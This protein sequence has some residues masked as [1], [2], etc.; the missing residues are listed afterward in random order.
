MEKNARCVCEIAP[1][2]CQTMKLKYSEA[3]M[4]GV[5]VCAEAFFT[6]FK[7]RSYFP[8]DSS[9]KVVFKDGGNDGRKTVTIYALA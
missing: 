1:G 9:W 6:R 2:R 8:A 7:V 4:D 5:F 3:N